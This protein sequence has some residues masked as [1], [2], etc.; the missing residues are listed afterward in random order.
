MEKLDAKI[1]IS[2]AKGTLG[3][4]TIIGFVDVYIV[5]I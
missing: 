4:E 5:N 3:A 1:F 2:T